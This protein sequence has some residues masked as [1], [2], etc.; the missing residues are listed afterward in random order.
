MLTNNKITGGWGRQKE[1]EISLQYNIHLRFCDG[2]WLLFR[3]GD[4][5][6]PRALAVSPN[7]AREE[8]RLLGQVGSR[9]LAHAH[10]EESV[11]KCGRGV[12]GLA[13]L[14]L[15]AVAPALTVRVQKFDRNLS[16][17]AILKSC[18][19]LLKREIGKPKIDH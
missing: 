18:M 8:H 2:R 4:D 7:A 13:T 6:V 16:A 12:C 1:K 15:L 11:E 3:P 17:L 10:A 5:L 14:L 9:L 19:V